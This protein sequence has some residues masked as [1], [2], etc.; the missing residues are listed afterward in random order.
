MSRLRWALTALA[1][2]YVVGY[3]AGVVE[4]VMLGRKIRAQS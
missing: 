1:G 4:Y 3:L 2:L